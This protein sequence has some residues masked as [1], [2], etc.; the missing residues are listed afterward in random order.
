MSCLPLF[1]VSV[2]IWTA[3]PKTRGVVLKLAK[4]FSWNV[5]SPSDVGVILF[6]NVVCRL[7]ACKR[8]ISCLQHFLLLLLL[9]T[10]SSAFLTRLWQ[11]LMWNKNIYLDRNTDRFRNHRHLFYLFLDISTCNPLCLIVFF[12]V[13]VCRSSSGGVKHMALGPE[14]QRV[15]SGPLDDFGHLVLMHMWRLSKLNSE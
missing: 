3:L 4:H 9:L 14:C 8:P 1:R 6:A 12:N 5:L 11:T 13:Y 15:Q 7:T 2:W 10:R